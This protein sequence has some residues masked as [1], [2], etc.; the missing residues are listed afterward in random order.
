MDGKCCA[1]RLFSADTKVNGWLGDGWVVC[2][3]DMVGSDDP[4]LMVGVYLTR[5]INYYRQWVIIFV[6]VEWMMRCL[7]TAI[8]YDIGWVINVSREIAFDGWW[9]LFE[10]VQS[11][12]AMGVWTI[13]V[14][15]GDVDTHV[16]S[17][18]NFGT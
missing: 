17:L 15:V 6:K 9:F 8:D 13:M 12:V 1:V 3:L 7:L 2:A 18:Y 5:L 11:E 10:G 4:M 16:R 14:V